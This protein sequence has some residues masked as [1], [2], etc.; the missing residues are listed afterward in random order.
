MTYA[1][2]DEALLAL[3]ATSPELRS[4]APNHAPMVVEALAILG[5]DEAAPAWIE[6]YRPRLAPGPRSDGRLDNDWRAALGDFSRL[7]EWQNHFRIELDEASW[8][9][10]LDRWLPRL[11]SGSMAAGTHGIIRCGHAARALA[12]APTA[13]RLNELA[14]ALAYCAARYRT[15]STVPAPDGDLDLETAVRRLPL[16]PPGL[17]RRGFPPDIVKHLDG[18]PDFAAAVRRLA[19]PTGIPAALGQLAEIGA[20]LYLGNATRHPLVL[21]HAVTGPA[22]VQLLM[23]YASPELAPI[24]FAYAWQ[25]VAAWAAAF[26]SGFNGGPLPTTDAE[27]NEIVD[28]SVESGDEHAIKLTEACRRLEASHPSPV[29]RA[30]ADDW[31][32]R[33]V[34]SRAWT[35]QQLAEAGIRVRLPDA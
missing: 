6:G 12:D 34:E 29:F 11:I 1:S 21:L 5:R 14:D 22:A 25:A 17:D 20:R 8:K 28:L 13:P 27:W 15:I 9:E 18:R 35:Q 32:H 24:A 10:V 7:G 3:S 19:P 31:V 23:A 16:L 33:V 26:S 30:T 2:L 4:G